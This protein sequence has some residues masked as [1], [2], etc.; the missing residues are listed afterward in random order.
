MS[1]NPNAPICGCE[2]GLS[3]IA[4]Q[5]LFPRNSSDREL[6]KPVESSCGGDPDIAF[7]IL[8]ETEDDVT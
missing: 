8:E 6:S 5:T 3:S 2:H 4:G 7:T 1:A